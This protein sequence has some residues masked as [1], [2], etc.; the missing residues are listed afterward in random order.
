MRG[1]RRV[2]AALCYMISIP[3]GAGN[4]CNSPLTA[5]CNHFFVCCLLSNPT[6]SKMHFQFCF[7]LKKLIRFSTVIWGNESANRD[8]YK[9]TTDRLN[10]PH[11][12]TL[13]AQLNWVA[14]LASRASHKQVNELLASAHT[15]TLECRL[16]RSAWQS[17]RSSEVLERNNNN[18]SRQS[19]GNICCLP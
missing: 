12:T 5:F 10:R 3:I 13:R 15:H 2:R 7:A 1:Q 14:L 4:R 6:L 19:V 17:R 11:S 9:R 18:N 8:Q 16:S